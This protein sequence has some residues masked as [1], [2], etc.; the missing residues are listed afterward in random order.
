VQPQTTKKTSTWTPTRLQNLLRHKSGRYYAR[1]YV[2]GKEIW[3]SLGTSLF[4]VAEIKLADFLKQYRSARRRGKRIASA[5]ITFGDASEI[6][7]ENLDCRIDIKQRT[8]DYWRETLKGLRK[9]WPELSDMPL[10]SITEPDLKKWAK[11]YSEIASDARYNNT[12]HLLRHVLNVGIDQGV[13][14]YNFADKLERKTISTKNPP[15]PTLAQFNALLSEMWDGHG[16]F[17]KACADLTAGLA[18][19]GCRLKEARWLTWGDIDFESGRITIRGHPA[20]GTKSGEARTVR[21]LPDAST[22]FKRMRKD[23]SNDGPDHRV[24]RVG[25]CQKAM[26]RA[27][28]KIGMKR[29]THHDLRHFFATRCIESG[30]DIPT[31]A[32]WLGHRDRGITLMKRYGHLR[33]EH[34]AAAAER[35]SFQAG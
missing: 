29:I 19:T 24:F 35:V 7:L 9:S 13:L 20:T 32:Y 25:E 17:S 5:K 22:R 23:F 34:A 33:D 4:S 28:E 26:N 3:Q 1:A 12:V 10:R 18:F 2:G 15:L 11:R 16:R 8:R 27:M 14:A 30:V 21:L 6:H 31:I